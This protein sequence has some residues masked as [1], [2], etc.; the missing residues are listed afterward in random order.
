M[1]DLAVNEVLMRSCCRLDA[2][3]EQQDWLESLERQSGELG[4]EVERLDARVETETARLAKLWRHKPSPEA[5]PELDGEMLET[6]RP[7]GEA[8]RDAEK[9]VADAK[10]ELDALR[11]HERNYDV[12]LEGALTSSEQLGLPNDIESAGELVSMLRRRLKAEQKIEQAQRHVTDMEAQR[13]R[14]IEGQVLPIEMFSL[15]V[16]G[17]SA[18]AVVLFWS[19][20]S[21]LGASR[22]WPLAF[23]AALGCVFLRY[24]LEDNRATELDACRQQ[25]ADAQ[26]KVKEARKETTTLDEELPLKEGSVVVRLQ[27]AEKHLEELERMLPVEAERRKASQRT[28][29]ADEFFR[30]AKEELAGAE[31]EWRSTLRSVGLPDETTAAEI[32]KLAGQYRGLAEIRS[33]AEAKQEE[34]ERCE[35]EHEKLAR[36][37]TALAEEAELVLEE[38]EVPE[39]LEHLLSER[40]LQQG[41]I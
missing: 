14:L 4:E 8:V 41:R 10:R 16:A 1:K 33:K 7:A 37:I 39:Q 35:R 11:G 23:L 38:A 40:R 36:R 19:W 5:A 27:H 22:W 18:A 31:K 13:D 29:S 20:I 12:Q 17:F 15:L 24:L 30:S 25:L 6:L 21:P 9:L 32:E 3:G 28:K 34:I 2:L 26:R